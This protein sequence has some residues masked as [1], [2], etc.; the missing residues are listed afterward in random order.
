[1]TLITFLHMLLCYYS[2][3][4]CIAAAIIISLLI[5]SP[6]MAFDELAYLDDT[7]RFAEQMLSL[8]NNYRHN[9]GLSHLSFDAK[10]TGLAKSHSAEMQHRGALSHDGFDERFHRSGHK[11]CVENVGWNYATAKELFNAWRNSAGH[12]RNMRA[13]DI[14]RVGI[15]RIGQYVTF[16]SCN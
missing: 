11:S 9:N 8:I 7:S 3:M 5:I 10:L 13:E 14:R 4:K 1:V 12:D 16:F 6:S 15:S 2:C